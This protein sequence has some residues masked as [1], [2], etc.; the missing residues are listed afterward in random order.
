MPSA[1]TVASIVVRVL[2]D[3]GLMLC[4]PVKGISNMSNLASN[5]P[6]QRTCVQQNL[7]CEAYA[8]Q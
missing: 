4:T 1:C 5:Y 7:D 3:T 2:C 6:D 8:W